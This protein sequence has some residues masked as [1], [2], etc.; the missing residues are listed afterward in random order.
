VRSA[1]AVFPP[2]QNVHEDMPVIAACVSDEQR[3]HFFWPLMSWY[4]PI[5]QATQSVRP[6]SEL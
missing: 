6:V 1:E 5:S 4:F 2:G 3:L